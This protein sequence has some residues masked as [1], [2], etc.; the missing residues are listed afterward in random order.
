MLVSTKAFSITPEES[1]ISSI[2]EQVKSVAKLKVLQKELEKKMSES[3]WV[4][5]ETLGEVTR[6]NQESFVGMDNLLIQ[7]NALTKT[8]DWKLCNSPSYKFSAFQ[9]NAM[10]LLAEANIRSI[11]AV[12]L[13]KED[14]IKRSKCENKDDC[15]QYFYK[16][17]RIYQ[18]E[19]SWQI[20]DSIDLAKTQAIKEMNLN[21]PPKNIDVKKK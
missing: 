16:Q 15:R 9:S 2:S 7:R 20:L 10:V 17:F 4:P 5:K 21:K 1:C 13:H 12:N 19:N 18:N 11:D 8:K 6:S 14:I 3:D